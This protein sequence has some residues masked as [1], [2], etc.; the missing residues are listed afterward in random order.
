LV[1][2]DECHVGKPV[3]RSAKRQLKPTAPHTDARHP[4]IALMETAAIM[5]VNVYYTTYLHQALRCR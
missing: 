4:G 3:G 1:G 5:Q 2:I